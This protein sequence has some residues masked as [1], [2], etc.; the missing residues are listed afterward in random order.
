MTAP[1]MK[2][3]SLSADLIP[4]NSQVSKV[5]E[6]KSDQTHEMNQKTA[7]PPAKGASQAL[8]QDLCLLLGQHRDAPLQGG[9]IEGQRQVTQA[10]LRARVHAARSVRACAGA[11][12]RALPLRRGFHAAL[13]VGVSESVHANA[14]VGV[15]ESIHVFSRL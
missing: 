12:A 5:S 11:R 14:W 3:G 15:C 9:A 13:C 4:W 2:A 1:N 10:L 8:E 6:V 7:G